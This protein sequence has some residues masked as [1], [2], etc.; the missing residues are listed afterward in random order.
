MLF[1]VL[2]SSQNVTLPSLYLSCPLFVPFCLLSTSVA[3]SSSHSAFSQPQLPTLRPVLPSLNL[4]CPLFVPF[5]HLSTS[6]AHSSPHSTFSQLQLP[7]LRPVLPSLKLSCPLFAPFCLLSTSVALSSPR[8]PIH[9]WYCMWGYLS[10]SVQC[11]FSHR[12]SS[13][14]I[15][16]YR[17][18]SPVDTHHYQLTLRTVDGEQTEQWSTTAPIL[19]V[20]LISGPKHVALI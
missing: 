12:V 8:S 10:F 18:V 2:Q 13:W 9:V 4:S 5:C 16:R 3:H 1:T 7:T 19:S 14:S 20:S 6:L 15:S 17:Y 11:Y